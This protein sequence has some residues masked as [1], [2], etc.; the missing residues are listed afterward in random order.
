MPEE[1]WQVEIVSGPHAGQC[2]AMQAGTVRIGRAATNDVVLAEDATVSGHHALLS[3][4][5]GAWTIEDCGSK[6]GTFI[7]NGERRVRIAGVTL[8][9]AGQCFFL[10]SAGLRIVSA[11]ARPAARAPSQGLTLRV[12]FAAE[13]LRYHLWSLAA[14]GTQYSCACGL[15]ELNTLQRRVLGAVAAQHASSTGSAL[16]EVAQVLVQHLFPARLVERLAEMQGDALVISHPPALFGLPWEL[17]PIG[18]VPL[19]VRMPLA[20]QVVLNDQSIA[21]CAALEGRPRW[22]IIANP[23]GDLPETQATAETLLDQLVARQP[24]AS[25]AFVAGER[26]TRLDLLKRLETAD[27]VYYTGHA[28]HDP[29]D[30]PASGW[31]LRDGRLTGRD[32][33]KLRRVPAFVFA[34]A[35]ESGREIVNTSGRLDADSSAG[36]AGSLLLAGVRHYL[37][38]QWPVAVGPAALFGQAVLD[39]LLQG[40]EVA[41]AVQQARRTVWQFCP[42]DPAWAA[43]TLFGDPA[44]RLPDV[45]E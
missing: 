14:T 3:C 31:R 5:H 26:A 39:R 45:S 7:D 40:E 4:R 24:D 10:G 32:F 12:E 15:E 27:I 37:G 21:R 34:N 30:P 13:E 1:A 33:G 17:L 29:A 19:G 28:A 22:L 11:A 35:C 9:H 36:L 18:D 44:W 8:V 2:M 16:D 6:N 23:T 42:A 38:T 25:V 20:R 43:Y 41:V